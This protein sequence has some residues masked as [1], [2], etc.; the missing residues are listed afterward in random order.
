M[1]SSYPT[2]AQLRFGFR[3]RKSPF[4]EASRRAGCTHYSVYNHMYYPV[5]YGD[6]LETDRRLVEGVTIWDVAVERQV[7]ITGP[8]ASRFVELLTPRDLSNCAVGQCKY[9][10]SLKIP[11]PLIDLIESRYHNV[12]I[13]R[14]KYEP[15]WIF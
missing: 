10:A 3:I 5:Q 7:Q 13:M 12:E 14:T 2:A 6:P 11:T 1:P 4:F 8:D 15:A 9:R